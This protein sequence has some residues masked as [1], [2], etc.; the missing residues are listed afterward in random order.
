MALPQERFEEIKKELLK[1]K[2]GLPSN[3]FQ[4]IKRDLFQK[5][6]ATAEAR[7][8]REAGAFFPAV[9]GESPFS[10]LPKTIGNIPS[11]AINLVKNL[12]TAVLNPIE[13]ATGIGR[14]VKGFGEAGGRKILEQT[15]FKE[16]VAQVPKSESEQTFNALT[17][18]LKERFG[19]LDA[20][21]RTATN[22]PVGFATDILAVVAPIKSSI[23]RIPG[24]PKVDKIVRAPLEKAATKLEKGAEK[25][26]E[27]VF[28]PTKEAQKVKAKKIIPEIRKRKIIAFSREGLEA[29]IASNLESTGK[30]IDVEL[31][32]IPPNTQLEVLPILNAIEETKSKFIV[33][34]TKTIAEPQ[35]FKA[36]ND[37]Q[38]IIASAASKGKISFESLRSLKQ[39]WAATVDKS[40]G[41]Q[42]QL[43][44]IDRIDIKKEAVTSMI[45]ELAK[46]SP[47]LAKLNAEYTL[48]KNAQDVLGTTLVR[49][50][51]QSIPLT[52]QIFRVVGATVGA[53]QGIIGA[54]VGFELA[55]KFSAFVN[56]T[57]WRTVSSATKQRL[58][59]ALVS[60]D[61]VNTRRIINTLLAGQVAEEARSAR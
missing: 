35:A 21:Q 42:K 24:I 48:W 32:K 53:G 8:A 22:D 31:E 13:T 61:K 14:A 20:L 52:Q 34:G 6:E 46:E 9:T 44:D 37:I 17:D 58:A 1:K 3:D 5:K 33:K 38:E 23:T 59:E 4:K 50:T 12:G 11:S 26:L 57:A 41:F 10:A 51:G 16:Q 27:Q 47:D 60:G 39:I 15:R 45:R 55:S 28:K 19:S 54:I 30:K 2:Q 36:A 40:K 49:T 29:K 7:S 56:S 25:S 43:S 18:V